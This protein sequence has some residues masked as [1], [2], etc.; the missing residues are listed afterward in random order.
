[1]ASSMAALRLGFILL[2]PVGAFALR[3]GSPR[4]FIEGE[5]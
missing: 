5:M 4:S 1:M 2:C 3:E